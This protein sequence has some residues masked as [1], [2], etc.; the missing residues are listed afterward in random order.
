VAPDLAREAD[1]VAALRRRAAAAP[2][3]GG[4]TAAAAA[5]FTAVEG[6][7]GVELDALI[8]APDNGMKATVSHPGYSDMQLLGGRMAEAGLAVT[9]NATLEDGGRV[10][11]DISIGAR[12]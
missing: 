10:V 12:P 5:L 8:A 7:E 3:P 1:P 11:S 9:E 4:V 6:I 2:P